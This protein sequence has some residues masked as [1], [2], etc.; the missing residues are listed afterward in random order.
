MG[1]LRDRFWELPLAEL[2]QAEWE[3]LCDG[4]GKCCLHKVEDEDTGE[5]RRWFIANG[6]AA[7]MFGDIGEEKKNE[8]WEF[9]KWWMSAAT[10]SQ[11]AFALQSTYGPEYVWLSGNLDAVANSTIDPVDKAVILEMVA[12]LADVPRTPGQY[13]LERGLSNVWNTVTFDGTPIRIAID[14]AVIDINREIKK[15]MTEVGY[16]DADGNVLVQ[17]T[18][19]GADWVQAQ[20]AAHDAE[21][22]D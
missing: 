12:W 7:I 10:Q 21:G 22:G 17:Y 9:L 13:L 11:F 14:E 1:A 3:A 15:K 4:C 19:R 5:I 8:S 18:V 20:I 16:I 2:D 6:S